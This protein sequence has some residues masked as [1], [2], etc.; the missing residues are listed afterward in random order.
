MPAT[1]TLR[2]PSAATLGRA[3]ARFAGFALVLVGQWLIL[4]PDDLLVLPFAPA[5]EDLLRLGV[6]NLNNVIPGLALTLA[7][8]LL[9]SASGA[10]L[11]PAAPE[12]G[13]E[14]PS[15]DW[16]V[17]LRSRRLALALAG[18]LAG[19]LA[20]LVLLLYGVTRPEADKTGGLGWLWLAALALLLAALLLVDRRAR[21]RLS[22]GLGWPDAL[23]I[24]GLLAAGMAIGT[25]QLGSLPSSMV[26]DE[27][28]FWQTARAIDRGEQQHTIFGL[29]AYSYPVLSNFYQAAVLHLFGH[30]LWSW[31][32]SSVIA[33]VLAVVP[34]FLL[35]REL[36]GRRVAALAGLA[37]V[38]LPYFIAFER[39]GY[40]NSQSILPVALSL[41]LL[42]A[43]LRRSSAL[44]M[45]LGGV[46][47]GLGFYTYTAGRLAAVVAALFLL[48]LLA[49]Q[50]LRRWGGFGPPRLGGALLLAVAFGL[51]GVLTALPQLA[52]ANT[53]HPELLRYKMLE[54]LLPNTFYASSLFS[55]D[56]LFRDYL[57]IT[58]D[59]QT[60]FYR[61][62][63]YARLLG[64]GVVRTLLV[65]H[66]KGLVYEHFISGPLAGPSTVGLYVLGLALLLAR[67]LRPGHLLLLLWF[68]AGLVLLSMINTFPPRYQHTVPVI[69]ALAIMLG[70]GI[71]A[72]ADTLAGE[73][74]GRARALIG[75]GL[76]AALV[77][78]MLATNLRE[79][80][81]DVQ[82]AH[83]PSAAQI[84]SFAGLELREPRRLVYVVSDP[85]EGTGLPWLLEQIPNRAIYQV[86]ARAE[87]ASG[88]FPLEPQQP[89][90]F[91]F[92]E[93]DRD[94]VEPF[95]EQRLG[96]P[97]VP[98]LHFTLDDEVEL[99]EYSFEAP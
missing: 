16:S 27:G 50:L 36:F 29:G 93:R 10:G 92:R 85:Q 48:A 87:L 38:A 47:G 88:A 23:L 54:S 11:I 76:T 43:G 24:G 18:L 52:Y 80:F 30:S 78:V 22:P 12:A 51:G 67:P 44:Y 97:V 14:A 25:H 8:G 46:A 41:Y 53:H 2:I 39:L 34:T 75:G 60:L 95:L 66:Y 72:L 28:L 31:R 83:P 58:V 82:K 6:V 9:F 98:K 15:P 37:M 86:V 20:A 32:L 59:D 84:V 56:E 81:V 96:Q 74:S 1:S 63:L 61:P 68:G 26:G 62:D 5:V 57:P 71:A 55:E 35:A 45:G 89:Y 17:L 21:A 19:A 73:F 4:H 3:F 40:N 79:Y 91:F 77:A 7:G 64:R 42:Y 94:V 99:A 13:R 65:F 70:L 69:P 49:A 33:A 90:T